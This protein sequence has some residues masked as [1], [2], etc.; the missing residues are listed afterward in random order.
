MLC[1]SPLKSTMK[2]CSSVR[3]TAE[4]A[5]AAG[6]AVRPMDVFPRSLYCGKTVCIQRKLTRVIKRCIHLYGRAALQQAQC[7][8]TL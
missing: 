4:A 3:T 7:L 5:L 8:V 1:I 2:A 6:H